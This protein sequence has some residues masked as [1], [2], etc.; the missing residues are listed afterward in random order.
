MFKHLPFLPIFAVPLL[1]SPTPVP[2]TTTTLSTDY[3]SQGYLLALNASAP[4]FTGAGPISG[5]ITSR[6]T[7]TL[8]TTACGVFDGT[9]IIYNKSIGMW[10]YAFGS[11]EGI[12]GLVEGGRVTCSDT[13]IESL[14][15]WSAPNSTVSGVPLHM[16]GWAN[17]PV[18]QW[19]SYGVDVDVWNTLVDNP[20][21]GVLLE[22]FA[23]SFSVKWKPL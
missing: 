15:K 11:E 7:W 8:D 23:K 4:Y 17:W 13:K 3:T 14:G 20:V 6:F 19:P 18:E 12:C 1:A 22:G 21:P 16:M 2:L 5:C 10:M 9:R